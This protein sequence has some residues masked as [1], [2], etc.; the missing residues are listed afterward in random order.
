MDNSFYQTAYGKSGM[1]FRKL[2]SRLA[3]KTKSC[4]NL[5]VKPKHNTGKYF[6]LF[7][8]STFSLEQPLQKLVTNLA[9]PSEE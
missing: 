7:D 8:F 2:R 1:K 3:L 5:K 9:K 6:G 4:L